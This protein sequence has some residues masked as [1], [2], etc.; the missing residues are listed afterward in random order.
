M[1]LGTNRPYRKRTMTAVPAMVAVAALLAGCA[2]LETR[3]DA[4]VADEFRRQGSSK[5]ETLSEGDIALL[6]E[7][8][9]RYI[10]YSGSVGKEKI[11][12]M[13]I[14]FSSEM[15]RTP[16]GAPLKASSRQY[17]FYGDLGRLFLMNARMFGLP[18]VARHLYREEKATFIV[19][20]AS[21]FTMV[22]ASGTDLSKTETVTLLNDMCVFAPAA[23]VDGRLQWRELSARETEVTLT[24]GPY[25]VSA[26]LT[27]GENGELTDFVSL[28]RSALQD[29]GSFKA[30]PWSTPVSRYR[31]I[32]GRRI[33]TYGETIWRRETG[34]F[35]YGRFTLV[36]IEYNVDGL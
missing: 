17:N 3:F 14:S 35:V 24:N 6:P 10:R 25:T 8:V 12:N 27:F 26:T 33:P 30:E 29:D 1:N 15:F 13:R 31:N 28:D 16:G 4:D 22:D 19:R 36:D 2:S 7:T 32:R 11:R 34:D 23:L 5:P 18:V 21:L 9:K 20:A